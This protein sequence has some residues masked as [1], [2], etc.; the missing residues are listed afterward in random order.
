[1]KSN[2]RGDSSIIDMVFVYKPDGTPTHNVTYAYLDMTALKV[3]KDAGSPV[4]LFNLAS[5]SGIVNQSSMNLVYDWTASSV[6][7][8]IWDVYALNT[9]H[10]QVLYSTFPGDSD[11]RYNFALLNP[12]T[13]T[14]T[15]TEVCAAGGSILPAGAGQPYYSG[16]MSLSK[17]AEDE[18]YTS[19]YIGSQFEIER[20]NSP[21]DGATWTSAAI[22]STSTYKQM[23]P[24]TPVNAGAYVPVLW[25]NGTYTNYVDDYDENIKGL[26]Y[27]EGGEPASPP[28]A[29][30]TA[31]VTT[32]TA[33][34]TVAFTFTG[35]SAD[36]YAW[37]WG[38]G[39]A[40]GTTA[41]PSHQYAA[42]GGY[43]V[44]LTVTNTSTGLSASLVKN[45]LIVVQAAATPTPA[46][47]IYPTATFSANKTTNITAPLCVQFTFTG[48]NAA[49][50]LWDFGDDETST[51]QNPVHTY[52]ENGTYTVRLSATNANGTRTTTT[53]IQVGPTEETG[54][55]SFQLGLS[56]WTLI[57]F[58][59]IIIA[60]I[61][62][63][64]FV[65]LRAANGEG[66]TNMV[67]PVVVLAIVIIAAIMIGLKIMGG[68]T[69]L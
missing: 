14:F 32:G 68:I 42:A 45:A 57:I 61:A 49:S 46:P 5:P 1:M 65:V 50:Y 51:D 40:N 48:A 31:N 17:T 2:T 56:D 37:S 21:D 16:G 23:R 10:V 43:N 27:L 15:S 4:E 13:H 34:L 55:T 7:A 36:T 20:W 35:S 22:T 24:I 60:L 39:T 19:R 18:F 52:T 30:F 66:D 3:Y 26:Y 6:K 8:W 25:L 9:G 58:G 62:L 64:G 33:P 12:S 54:D 38:D 29:N 11:H 53:T 28:V 63:V 67:L 59:L 69:G 44:I 41:N 47:K